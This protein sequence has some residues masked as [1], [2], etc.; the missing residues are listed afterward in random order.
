M[1]DAVDA[2]A[3]ISCMPP[4][5]MRARQGNGRVIRTVL[6]LHIIQNET[7]S[8]V[9]RVPAV[10][11]PVGPITPVPP[12]NNVIHL[13][14]TVLKT[15]H[16]VP[17]KTAC[18]IPN[19]SLNKHTAFP[20]LKESIT[21]CIVLHTQSSSRGMLVCCAE[22]KG[23]FPFWVGH[24]RWRGVPANPPP[25]PRLILPCLVPYW[26]LMRRLQALWVLLERLGA[27]AGG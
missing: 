2:V 17:H 16:P 12:M 5:V 1:V 11:T 21:S 18:P 27:H 26:V 14:M 10:L 7:V 23:F 25:P 20:F 24:P 9:V 3:S 4:T 6:A 8:Q 15:I 19:I 13:Q 22:K